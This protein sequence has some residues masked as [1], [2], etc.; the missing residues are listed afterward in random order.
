MIRILQTFLILGGGCAGAVF[1][2]NA[3]HPLPAAVLSTATGAVIMAWY[4]L[5]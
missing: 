1:L 2:S 4:F 3:G 5:E